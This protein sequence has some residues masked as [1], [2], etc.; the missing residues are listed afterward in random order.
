MI[1]LSILFCFLLG[2]FYTEAQYSGYTLLI[3]PEIFKKNLGEA[4]SA[5]L[6]IQSD[7]SQ[8]KSLTMLKEKLISTGKFWFEKKDKLRMEYLH[9]YTYLMVLNAGRIFVRD[10]QKEN[11]ISANSN[12]A[13]QQVNRIL[14]DCVSGKTLENTDFRS[15]VFESGSSYMIELIPLDKN[16]STIYKNINIVIDKKDYSAN[17]VEMYELSGDKSI[18]RFQNKII[19]ASIPDSIFTIL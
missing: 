6:T 8:E 5:T 19:N 14:I 11:K 13:L 10:G 18:L 1:R 2:S 17:S 3:H 9:P 12:K 15:R 7:F 16:L 4:T